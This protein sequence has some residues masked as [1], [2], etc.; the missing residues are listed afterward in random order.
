MIKNF[1]FV[2]LF[3]SSAASTVCVCGRR[4]RRHRDSSG[5]TEGSENGVNF[6]DVDMMD[7]NIAA[8]V[9]TSLSVSPKSPTIIVQTKGV[10]IYI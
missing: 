3:L 7:E 1:K 2:L 6:D 8:M 5:D 10:I 9:L 4:Q